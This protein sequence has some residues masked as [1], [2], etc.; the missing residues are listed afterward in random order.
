MHH[1][2]LGCEGVNLHLA[3][4]SAAGQTVFHSHLHVIPRYADDD[5]RIHFPAAYGSSP[6]TEQLSEIAVKIQAAVAQ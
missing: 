5:F 1:S 6:S 3:D 4:G 2:A